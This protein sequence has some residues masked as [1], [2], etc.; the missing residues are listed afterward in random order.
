MAREN[1]TY[2][3]ALIIS[4]LLIAILVVTSFYFVSEYKDADG[5]VQD[6]IAENQKKTTAVKDKVDE[7]NRY[8]EM[9][10]F[11][12]SEELP[13]I[14][15]QFNDEM[16][17]YAAA[18]ED[19]DQYYRP[20]LAYLVDLVGKKNVALDEKEDEILDK[21]ALYATSLTLLQQ[22]IVK[23]KADLATAKTDLAKVDNTAKSER[24]RLL[25][26]NTKLK[27]DFDRDLRKVGDELSQKKTALDNT[28]IE[29]HKITELSK[30]RAEELRAVTKDTFE[31]PH[32]EIRWVNQRNGTVWINLGRADALARLITFSVY[33][34][35][36][37]N[38]T[39][40]GSKAS[41]EVTQ[42]LGEHLADA[43]VIEDTISDPIMPG[44]K[45][46][47]PVWSPGEQKRFALAG[48]MDI[49]GDG[50]SDQH[51]VRN[52]ITM[53]GGVVDCE[54]DESGKR[55][56]KMTV[57]TRY[58]VLG[59]APAVAASKN[60]T[61]PTELI[62]GYTRM[63]GEADK[64]G[65]QK[66]SLADL[67]QRMGWKKQTR[68]VRFGRGANPNDFRAKP[69]EGGPRVSSGN[70]SDIFKPRQPPTDKPT[71]RGGAY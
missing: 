30:R 56:G 66:I 17:T 55:R 36:I 49:D 6:L 38:L 23:L 61:V 18:Y 71:P 68:V 16:D 40:G 46:H 12:P 47:T 53:N 3:I 26:D 37:N 60:A 11:K 5:K 19:I 29:L 31:V 52:L 57:N 24:Q 28:N 21:E 10:G 44:D 14:E 15:K 22:E 51:I 34:A 2:Q 8:K 58:L 70:V 65:I 39:D 67:L 25:A 4:V 35:D 1:Q 59:D 32:G 45:I 63:I 13:S 69:P 9:M 50:E 43:R 64:L 62:A 54:T 7:C 48:F 42:L 27:E 20:L 33:P 41:I